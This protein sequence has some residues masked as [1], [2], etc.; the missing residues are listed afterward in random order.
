MFDKTGDDADDDAG[1]D[2][3]DDD[4]AGDDGGAGDE[5]EGE[6]AVFVGTE[7]PSRSCG[8]MGEKE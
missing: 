5:G 3:G 4:G 1:D 7:F 6:A 2:D 8:I